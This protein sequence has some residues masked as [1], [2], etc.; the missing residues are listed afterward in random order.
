MRHA[1]VA[2]WGLRNPSS[3]PLRDA[4]TLEGKGELGPGD[5]AMPPGC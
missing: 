4:P 2:P 3:V 5:P 1:A